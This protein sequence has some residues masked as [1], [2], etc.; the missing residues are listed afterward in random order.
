MLA[1][2][3]STL[4]FA[5]FVVSMRGKTYLRLHT[6]FAIFA[7]SIGFYTLGGV[8]GDASGPLSPAL[9]VLGGA[10][11]GWSWL[12]ARALFRRPD[13]YEPVWPFVVVAL[14]ILTFGIV[15]L[16]GAWLGD[17]GAASGL[18]RVV[19][20]ING[21]ASSTVLLLV[22][23]EALGRDLRSFSKEERRFRVISASTYAL[24]VAIAGLW[25]RGAEEGSLAARV[26]DDIQVVASVVAVVLA[27]LAL[28]YREKHPLPALTDKTRRKRSAPTGDDV[29]LGDRILSLMKDRALFTRPDLKVA[30]L[31]R[32]LSEP[33]YKVTKSITGALGFSNF[34]QMINF[35][36]I[37]RAKEMLTDP[38]FDDQS[39]LSI[40]MDCGFGSIGPFNR[41]FKSAVETTPGRYRQGLGI[42]PTPETRLAP[43]A[44]SA[45]T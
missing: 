16:T 25:V 8:I 30:D 45:G 2:L 10:T 5:F 13:A 4:V 32:H 26:G 21:L 37:E 7:A 22:L 40:A 44:N 43:T 29:Q 36:R 31:A 20:N 17:A 28:V 39:I 38:A 35:F 42:T 33:D 23:V 6:Y 15:E 3:I 1:P 27:G 11:C 34:N 19:L 9:A 41:A 12:F 18:I 24:L 14:L